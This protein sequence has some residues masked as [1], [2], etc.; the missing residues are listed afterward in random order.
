MVKAVHLIYGPLAQ[1]GTKKEDQKI[2]TDKEKRYANQMNYFIEDFIRK[3]KN[4]G[5]A[6]I[7]DNDCLEGEMKYL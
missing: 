2:L 4:Q 5:D 3:I 7:A 6:F 1:I